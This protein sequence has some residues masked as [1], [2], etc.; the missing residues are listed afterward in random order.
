MHVTCAPL[1]LAEEKGRRRVEEGTR[2][3]SRREE[4]DH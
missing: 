2:K 3:E 1:D 4:K